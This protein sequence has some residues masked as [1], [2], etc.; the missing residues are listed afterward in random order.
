MDLSFSPDID[1]SL[2]YLVVL[3]FGLLSGWREVI[4]QPNIRDTFVIWGRPVTWLLFFIM[5]VSP[6]LMFWILDR[7]GALHDTSL[8]AAAI[9]GIAYTQI[10]Q[11]DTKYKAPGDTSPIWNF[12][13][14]LRAYAA[15][16]ISERIDSNR[17]AFDHNVFRCLAAAARP[18]A[19]P[20]P[21]SG[22]PPAS[23]PLDDFMA[24]ALKRAEDPADL[25]AKIDAE[26]TRLEAVKPALAADVVDFKVAEFIYRAMIG[27][28][29]VGFRKLL[30]EEGLIEQSLIDRYFGSQQRR[31][32]VGLM[33]L[34]GAIGLLLFVTSDPLG[35]VKYAER[36][37]LMF[38]IAK[39]SGTVSDLDRVVSRLVRRVVAEPAPKP[40]EAPAADYWILPLLDLLNDSTLPM[41]RVD[42]TLKVFL[43]AR[44]KDAIQRAIMAD[45]L[46]F[47]L[48]TS[49][50]DA[51]RRV[52]LNLVY[53]SPDYGKEE[54]QQP[55]DFKALAKWNPTEGDSITEIETKIDAWRAYWGKTKP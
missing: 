41:G 26:R 14:W 27:T 7:V 40:G 5:A 37:Y 29:E 39:A 10:V 19:A 22:S 47:L 32:V 46:V 34:A 21:P 16:K 20:P 42:A 12:L 53:L 28:D 50:V 38:R 11:G 23:K 6:A 52:H 4:A 31:V 54:G 30:V 51:R 48:R 25:R 45:R 1:A 3:F 9:V 55:A 35:W 36:E 13:T 18:S 2:C 43:T 33:V 8:I 15:K 44:D 49:N 17:R 24:I